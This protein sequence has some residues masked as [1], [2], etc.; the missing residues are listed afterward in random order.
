VVNEACKIISVYS[1]DTSGVCSAL[2]ELGGMTVIHD[3][4]GCN[5][6]YT[7]HDEPRW[8]DIP[9][10][11]YVSGLT[12]YEAI[13]GDEEKFI[14][15]CVTTALDQKPKFIAICASPIPFMVGMDLKAISKDIERRSNIP[16]ICVET[17]GMHSY[18]SGAG[19]AL[20]EWAKRFVKPKTETI[21]NTINILGCIPLDYANQEIVD[22]M[23]SCIEDGGLKVT[24][25]W[26][27]GDKIKTMEE[28]ASAMAN[29]V[30]SSTGLETAK[31][32]ES[33][34]GIPYVVGSPMGEVQTRE[35]IELLKAKKTT[36]LKRSNHGGNIAIIGESVVSNAIAR[37]IGEDCTVYSLIRDSANVLSNSDSILLGEEDLENHLK[38][39]TTVIGDGLFKSIVDKSTT[40]FINL[41]DFAFSGRIYLNKF[42]SLLG[43]KGDE[44]MK[45][46]L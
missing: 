37:L 40:K 2:Y 14:N 35:I 23:V 42:P 34:Y 27:M 16:S 30:V 20:C 11:M 21:E 1:A 15:D 26:S 24:S 43:K 19:M 8:Y 7:T 4:S 45:E 25:V 31:Y 18:I 3:A 17:N 22:D 28:S 5:S 44:W 13:L 38:S 12:E 46:N 32:L 39:F 6:S 36:T 10:M 9:S 33:E 41:P 29:L